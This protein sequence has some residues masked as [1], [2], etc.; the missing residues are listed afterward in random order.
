MNQTVRSSAPSA[1]DWR[2]IS[3][4]LLI[5]MSITWAIEFAMI[6]AG[7]RFDTPPIFA[8]LVVAAVMW[9]PAVGAFIV[10]KWVTR[11]GFA[12]A[13]LRWA[14]WKAFLGVQLFTPLVFAAIYLLTWA[15]GLAKIDPQLST[16]FGPMRAA[17]PTQPFPDPLVVVAGLSAASLVAAPWIN[18]VFGFGEE[19]GW[20]GYLLPKLLP[21][22]RARAVGIYGVIWGL[23]H[24][25][26]IAAGF[27]L[28]GHPVLGIFLMCGMAT[29]LGLTQLALL[30]RY[31][32]VL[33]TAFVH[34]AFNAQA[35]GIWRVLFVDAHPLLGGMTGLIGIGLIA[36]P[37][38]WLLS[39]PAK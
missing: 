4:Y 6:A 23:W 1:V 34:G 27:S 38:L 3:S 26:L 32:S 14:P 13:G 21:L 25:P 33:L 36:L 7:V 5:T 10:R 30:E 39:R 29:A 22:G 8:Q 19:F 12:T 11:E 20:T 17:S 37:G 24:A 35:Y 9:V 28:P 2:G 15:L 16:L 31:R 18:A